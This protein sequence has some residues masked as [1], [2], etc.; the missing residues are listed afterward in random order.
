MSTYAEPYLA[1]GWS[2]GPFGEG[3]V[4]TLALYVVP[5]ENRRL[6]RWPSIFMDWLV[7]EFER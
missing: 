6:S 7:A 5:N 4:L 2:V 3:E 1:S